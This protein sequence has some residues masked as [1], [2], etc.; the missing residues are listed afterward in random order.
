[1]KFNY[2]E[3]T[4]SSYSEK[5]SRVLH[6]STLSEQ[7]ADRLPFLARLRHLIQ[8]CRRNCLH[9][10]PSHLGHSHHVIRLCPTLL[11]I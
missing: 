2:L 1:M 3:Y 6:S 5:L 10:Q 7:S 8:T 9:L 11:S 4:N